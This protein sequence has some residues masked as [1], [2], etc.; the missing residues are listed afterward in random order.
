MST[1]N[2]DF[3]HMLE[4]YLCIEARLMQQETCR[5][6]SIPCSNGSTIPTRQR[7]V[8]FFLSFHDFEL[9]RPLK[10]STDR[11]YINSY[12]QLVGIRRNG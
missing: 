2:Y 10:P 12:Q 6:C 7:F 1:F 3:R 8:F 11:F 4:D 9:A 5:Y